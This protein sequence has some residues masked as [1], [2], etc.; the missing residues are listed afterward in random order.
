MTGLS[1]YTAKNA[2]N[3]STGINNQPA[4]PG[5][6]F[7]ALMTAIDN[8]AG[9]GGT[10]VVTGTGTNYFRAQVSG[11][12]IVG[13]F[14]TGVGT[15]TITQSGNVPS[16]I[17]NG[18]S[19]SGGTGVSGTGPQTFPS[20]STVT[21]TTSTTITVSPGA[22]GSVGG[23]A[24]F[25]FSSFVPAAQTDPSPAQISNNSII[26]FL[27]AASNWGTVMAFELRDGS[28]GGNMLM[29][30]YL[31]TFNWLPNTVAQSA[32]TAPSVITAHAHGYAAGQAV[33]YTEEYGGT[34]ATGTVGSF[35]SLAGSS[36]GSAVLVVTNPV[37]TDT[38][39]VLSG[40]AAFASS[41]SGNG[42]VRGVLQ[43]SI[44]SGVTASFGTGAFVATA[45]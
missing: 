14:G 17:A 3:W 5:S 25:T 6:V 9:S 38:F 20:T 24:T 43:Q 1:D 33:V 39:A 26:P 28:V 29:S 15:M 16:W 27:Q 30:D 34:A 35:T 12:A 2:L 4:V 22:N 19:I 10:E 7:L 37:T 32:G 41:N 44:P 21:G 8:D 31:G 40:T 13:G 18:M 23:S 45:A 42:L 11:T 36:T